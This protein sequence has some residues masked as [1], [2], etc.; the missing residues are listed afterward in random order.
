MMRVRI[1]L[2]V[3]LVLPLIRT[4]TQ[5]QPVNANALTRLF[6]VRYK[7]FTGSSFTIEVDGRQYLITAKHVLPGIKD[8]DTVYLRGDPSH[9]GTYAWIPT[10]VT[11]LKCEPSPVD[12]VV[13]APQRQ[14]SPT[15][16]LPPDMTGIVAGQ[17]VYFLGFPYAIIG[18]HASKNN[19]FP[20]PL[21]K[22]GTLSTWEKING[23]YV[24]LLVDGFINPGFSGGPLLFFD[25][26][27]RKLKVAGVVVG[28]IAQFDSVYSLDTLSKPPLKIA[29]GDFIESNSGIIMAFGIKSVLDAIHR[30]PVGAPIK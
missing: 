7:S 18:G 14:L 25:R 12:V 1:L 26:Q 3:L 27:Q 13:L 17:D 11:V 4:A 30:N 8:V 2:F 21:I 5:S 15:F 28:Y 20:L 24:E 19:W 10:P 23:E 6:L 16:E 29:T 9:D 22:S